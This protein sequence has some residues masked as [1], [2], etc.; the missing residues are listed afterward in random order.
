MQLTRRTRLVLL[1]AL[2]LGAALVG[3]E[4]LVTA[5]ALPTIVSDL[6]DW[7]QLRRASWVVNGYL[8]AYIAAMPLA[9]RLGDRFGVPGPFAASL[10]VFA[11]GSVLAGAA[12]DLDQLVAARLLQGAGGGAVVPLATAGASELFRGHERD[13]ALGAIGALTFLGMAVGPFVGAA[14]LDGLDFSAALGARGLS[15]S[16]LAALFAPAWRWIFFVGVPPAILAALYCW[17]AASGWRREH[18][19]V[20]FD[21]PGAALATLAL[22]AGLLAVT[23]L[24]SEPGDGLPSPL[25]S[26]LVSLAAAVLTAIRLRR[27]PEPFLDLRLLR[28]PVMAGAVLLSLLTGYALATA[29]VGGA[30][31][32]DRVRYGGPAEQRLALGG[33]AAAMA[34]GALVSGYALRRLGAVAVSVAGLA[35]GAAGLLAFSGLGPQGTIRDA[36]GGL[37]LFGLGF[38][39]TVTPRSAVAV[40][41]AGRRAFGLA[42][43]AVTVARMVGMALGLAVLTALGSERIEALSVVLTDA[44]ARDAVLPPELRGRP[45]QDGL[46]V[47]VLERWASEQAASILAG[48]FLVAAA[49]MALALLPALAMGGGRPLAG[50]AGERRDDDEDRRPLV[51]V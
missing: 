29:I 3:A 34:L 41:A 25:L 48:L 44:A 28:R 5:V 51:A 40:E 9:G 20:A 23:S 2:G 26:G 8:L 7:T 24:G 16:A 15:G 18:R 32:V 19:A 37:A 33:L 21:L 1:A 39:L 13:R 42:A 22:G 38:G 43:A 49:I 45:L 12:Q 11:L 35:V 36:A 30:V 6:A 4:L 46:V 10:A 14:V 17:A 47:D 50:A 31:F 27:A